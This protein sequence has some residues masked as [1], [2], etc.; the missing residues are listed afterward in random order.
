KFHTY[1]SREE[2]RRMF[3]VKGLH[4]RL[5]PNE[6]KESLEILSITVYNISLMKGTIKPMLLV[7]VDKIKIGM[8]K[9]KT[10]YVCYTKVIWDNYINKRRLAE[11]HRRQEWGHATINCHADPACLKC[12]GEHLTKKCK[13]P[14]SEP[15]KCINCSKDHPANVTIC[16]A[17]KK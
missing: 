17:Y 7:I 3:I 16:E 1:T 5:E 9:Q 15:A 8:L 12:A 10:Q 13:K 4:D 11:Y 2:K 6:V 14:V